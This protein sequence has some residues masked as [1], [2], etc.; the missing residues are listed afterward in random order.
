MDVGALFVALPL[1][2]LIGLWAGISAY[3][4]WPLVV[5][6]LFVVA[7]VPVYEAIAASILVDL[8]NAVAAS[9]V[10]LRRG[11][12]DASA[13]RELAAWSLPAGL[14]GALLAFALLGNY[15]ALFKS[16]A[17]YFGIA[18][19]SLLIARAARMPV[20]AAAVPA[21]GDAA[22]V[23]AALPAV[24]EPAAPSWL[25]PSSSKTVTRV[26]AVVTALLMGLIGMGGG[27]TIAMVLVVA[28]GFSIRNGV[29]TG[30][31]YSALALPLIL[32]AY[33]VFLRFE[34]SLA[35]ILAPCLACSAAAAFAGAR[36]AARIAERPLAFVVGGCVISAGI[37]ATAQ[38]WFLR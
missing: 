13:S 28:R 26:G 32:L 10:Y 7:D 5:P 4:G 35:P 14:L 38:S 31:L 12:I 30:I 21:G 11:D 17:G 23:T 33:L 24:I 6:L 8:V 15:T 19:G 29:G 18:L 34:F 27:F 36:S 9:S 20:A 3:S 2:V 37:V 25:T 1:S 16:S 22:F